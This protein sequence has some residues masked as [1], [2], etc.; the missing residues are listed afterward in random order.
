MVRRKSSGWR[1]RRGLP[2]AAQRLA[3]AGASVRQSRQK[4]GVWALSAGAGIV[5]SDR[6]DWGEASRRPAAVQSAHT[7]FLSLAL[8]AEKALC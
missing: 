4:P 8:P 6:L 1:S 7:R 3:P 2:Q 5:S